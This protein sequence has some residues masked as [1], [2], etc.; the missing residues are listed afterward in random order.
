MRYRAALRS[1]GRKM[2]ETLGFCKRG[3]KRFCRIGAERVANRRISHALVPHW[4]ADSFPL[5][6]HGYMV[7]R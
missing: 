3:P 2:A 7:R 6:D 5:M 1:E 4:I